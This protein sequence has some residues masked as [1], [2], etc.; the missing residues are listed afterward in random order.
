MSIRIR[1]KKNTLTIETLFFLIAE[2][3]KWLRALHIRLSDWCCTFSASSVSSHPVETKTMSTRII[4]NRIY[5]TTGLIMTIIF[6]ICKT[7]L[8][9][10]HVLRK[11][12]LAQMLS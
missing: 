12:K 8:T 5:M 1:D 6:H 3:A 9:Y 7:I 2:V 4:F 10:G 11:R